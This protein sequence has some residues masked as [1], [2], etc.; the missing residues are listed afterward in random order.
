MIFKLIAETSVFQNNCANVHTLL[1]ATRAHSC[2]SM[3]LPKFDVDSLFVFSHLG[4][5]LLKGVIICISLSIF[6]CIYYPFGFLF[7]FFE[8]PIE[9]SSPFFL[10]TMLFILK[11]LYILGTRCLSVIELKHHFSPCSLHF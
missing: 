4:R 3:S 10:K 2:C 1:P 11:Y 9:I 8:G 7:F 5:F 6:S